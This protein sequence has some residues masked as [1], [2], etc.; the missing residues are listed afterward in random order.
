VPRH[1][2]GVPVSTPVLLVPGVDLEALWLSA[3]TAAGMGKWLLLC[4]VQWLRLLIRF[5]LL[6]LLLLLCLGHL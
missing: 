1:A 5:L 6:L 4:I 3:A 2:G